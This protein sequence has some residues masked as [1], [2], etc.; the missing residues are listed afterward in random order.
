MYFP[1]SAGEGAGLI[2]NY[3]IATLY[4][5]LC[6]EHDCSAMLITITMLSLNV[7]W[8]PYSEI[9]LCK[10]MLHQYLIVGYVRERVFSNVIRNVNWNVIV[11]SYPKSR[12][13]HIYACVT[14]RRFDN[15][16]SY[17]WWLS[18]LAKT[19]WHIFVGIL[20]QNCRHRYTSTL[21]SRQN[22]QH[23]THDVSKYIIWWHSH[24]ILIQLSLKCASKCPV[25]N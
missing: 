10:T 1:L 12:T 21:R 16:V 2:C 25:N 6:H 4:H 17:L 9:Q 13:Q 7:Y 24:Y 22:G 20:G 23:I 18:W 3:R 15:F 11:F 19:E 14:L 5:Y 8:I